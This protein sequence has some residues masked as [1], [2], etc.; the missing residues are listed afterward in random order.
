MGY[1]TRATIVQSPRSQEPF[2]LQDGASVEFLGVVRGE[3]HGFPIDALE[4]EA[5][6]PMAETVIGRLV[7]AAR[8]SWPLHRVEVCHRV[9]RVP[10][11]EVSVLVRVHAPHR[12]QAFAACRFLIDQIKGD[13]PIWKQ[14]LVGDHARPIV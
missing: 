6:E 10:V 2:D 11:G 5:Y 1:L 3:E 4:Y 14:A 7:E 9:G 13:A 8:R 12:D